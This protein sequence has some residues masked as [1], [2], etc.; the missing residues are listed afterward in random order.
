MTDR[1]RRSAR[2]PT[3]AADLVVDALFGAGLA[4]PLAGEAARVVE[5]LNAGG[6]PVLAVDLPSGVDGR[7]GAAEGAA[8]RAARTVTFF[9][10][11]PGHLLLPGRLLCGRTEVAQI[12]ISAGGA[13]RHPAQDLPQHPAALARASAAA[14]R[15][16]TT[17]IARGHAFVV[18]R[19][20]ERH[21][22]RRGSPRW[23]RSASGPARSRSPRR[24]TRSSS[25]PRT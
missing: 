11:K 5:A 9:R 20:G 17:N 2:R 22:A 13:C 3:F 10:L 4:R 19:T 1:S 16:T 6:A 24:P 21:R 14:A 23:A 12:G 25:M 18:S 15:R 8:V 7:T